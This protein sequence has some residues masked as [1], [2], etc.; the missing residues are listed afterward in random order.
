MSKKRI[1]ALVAGA[2][3]AASAVILPSAFA[4]GDWVEDSNGNPGRLQT[5]TIQQGPN[6]PAE[7]VTIFI[8]E[9]K[10]LVGLDEAD[11]STY[12]QCFTH[13]A[14]ESVNYNKPQALDRTGMTYTTVIVEGTSYMIPSTTC[15]TTGPT[16][17]STSTSETSTSET[18]TSETSTSETST[19][20][21][22]TSETSTTET[23]DPKPTKDYDD[24]DGSALLSSG[25]IDDDSSLAGSA[26]LGLGLSALAGSAL[27][28]SGSSASSD[29]QAPGP[30]GEAADE[31]PAVT[32]TPAAAA[33]AD[34]VD[35]KA[36]A[37]QQAANAPAA[38]GAPAKAAPATQEAAQ[39][40]AAAQQ[41]QLA[42]T[43][44]AGTLIALAVGLIAAAAG[45]GLLVLRR[46]AN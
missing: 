44:V 5:I 34:F 30:R 14:N 37:Q 25:D 16:K 21:T 22:S 41:K 12:A 9:G 26:A 23:K 38:Q 28:G 6:D 19:S 45:A 10:A 27:L 2:S 46:R 4:Q 36:I 39:V 32:T 13:N 8:P 17:P 40:K 42:N 15:S 31:A 18:S 35:H 1:A 33:E 29:D 43:G 3:I 20:E 7:P 11:N 24:K